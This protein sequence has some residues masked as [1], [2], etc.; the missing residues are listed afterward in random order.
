MFKIPQ[1]GFRFLSEEEKTKIKWK[2]VNLTLDDGYFVKCDLKYP[3][4]IWEHTKDFPL[5]PENIEITYDIITVA[6]ELI[7]TD[8]WSNILQTKK[9][10]CNLFTQEENVCKPCT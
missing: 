6:K 7:G 2:E 8:L 5:C 3:E 10:D 4:E 1:E 9:V